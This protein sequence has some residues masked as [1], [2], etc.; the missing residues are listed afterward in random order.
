VDNQNVRM[1]HRRSRPS[2]WLESA[3]SLLDSGEVVRQQLEGNVA[4]KPQILGQ[5]DSAH[6]A[7][8]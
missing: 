8:A 7:F 3:N 2:F 1:I 5:V 4:P 6:P